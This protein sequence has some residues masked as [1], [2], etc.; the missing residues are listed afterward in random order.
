[1]PLR[2]DDTYTWNVTEWNGSQA[3]FAPSGTVVG[4]YSSDDIVSFAAN[5]MYYVGPPQPV[6]VGVE[7]G[8]P[9]IEV[10][11][12]YARSVGGTDTAIVVLRSTFWP[13]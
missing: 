4:L 5:P 8:E 6:R 2:A 13:L 11:P 9:P 3:G 1:M 12:V 10:F 7:L